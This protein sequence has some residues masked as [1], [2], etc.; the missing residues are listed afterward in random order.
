MKRRH[1]AG[2]S[3]LVESLDSQ[4]S[5][6]K[7]RALRLDTGLVQEQRGKTW[8]HR[9]RSIQV[10]MVSPACQGH[11]SQETSGRS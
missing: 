7:A 6:A 4:Q 1:D 9:Y 5:L 11:G 3:G 2:V 8:L 10:R